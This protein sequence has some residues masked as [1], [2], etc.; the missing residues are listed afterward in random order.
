MLCYYWK[1]T[2]KHL[3]RVSPYVS[4]FCKS[5]SESEEFTKFTKGCRYHWQVCVFHVMA[6]TMHV[7]TYLYMIWKA[8]FATSVTLDVSI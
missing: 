7:L 5:H 6:F 4:C 8:S 3:T 1:M 2:E